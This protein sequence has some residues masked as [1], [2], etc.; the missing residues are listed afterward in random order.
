MRI[1]AAWIWTGDG[2]TMPLKTD[3]LISIDPDAHSIEGFEDIQYGVLSAQKG[4]LTKEQNLSSFSLQ[5]IRKHSC[6]RKDA[7]LNCPLFWYRIRLKQFHPPSG[8]ST[9]KVRASALHG[10]KP[11]LP[12][13]LFYNSLTHG[14]TQTRTGSLGSKIGREY[15][16]LHFLGIPLAIVLNADQHGMSIQHFLH[17]HRSMLCVSGMASSAFCNRLVKSRFT[18]VLS[19][20]IITSSFAGCQLNI[21]L[22]L[23][24]MQSHQGIQAFHAGRKLHS[25]DCRYWRNCEKSAAI[26]DR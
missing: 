20:L 13:G 26:F 24:G 9:K 10:F 15:F 12:L 2:W 21:S 18:C 5:R 4:G 11:D 1:R 22:L 7:R 6:S 3:V 17:L 8:N 25:C 16:R 14:Q 19:A 23:Y